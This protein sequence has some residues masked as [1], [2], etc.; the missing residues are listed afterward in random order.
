[1]LREL[2]KIARWYKFKAVQELRC[3]VQRLKPLVHW[4]TDQWIRT[5]QI[6]EWHRY[7]RSLPIEK[8]DALE[9][10]PA[11]VAFWRNMA[12]RS[13]HSVQYPEFDI[14]KEFLPRTFDVVIAEQVFEHLPD[15]Y[16]AGRNVHKMLSDTGVF[17]IAVPF[18]VRIHEEPGD[19][20]RWTPTGFKVFLESCGF[21]AEVKSWGNR[22]AV[23]ANFRKWVEYGWLRDLRNEANFPVNVWAYARKAK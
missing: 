21:T 16:A 20:T 8:M 10:S 14:T 15:P 6:D 3:V 9:I 23:I 12:F 17:L 18:L 4:R 22:K 19:F 5:T 11:T 2:R 7:F 13:Y 1:M